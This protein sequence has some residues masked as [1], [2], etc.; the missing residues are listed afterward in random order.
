MASHGNWDEVNA[1]LGR[2]E[3]ENRRWRWLATVFAI[4][5]IVPILLAASHEKGGKTLEATKIVLKD[6][7]GKVRAELGTQPDGSAALSLLDEEGKNTVKLSG[8]ASGPILEMAGGAGGSV[9]LTSSTTGASLS[10]AKGNG[11]LA[12][13][14]NASGQ[15][16]IKMQDRD[17]KVVWNAP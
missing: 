10:L 15:P 16:S 8:Q 5:A 13:A 2:L 1:R 14:T 17:G 9:W 3:A 6:A 11:E 12:L 4:G 7:K